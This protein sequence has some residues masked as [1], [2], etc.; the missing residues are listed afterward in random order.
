MNRLHQ[1][2]KEDLPLP[3]RDP[4]PNQEMSFI[5]L[6]E[7]EYAEAAIHLAFAGSSQNLPDRL[8]SR[9]EDAAL[10]LLSKNQD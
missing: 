5:D 7:N 2:G 1:H 6:D 3:P 4:R 8:R 9:L 10:S